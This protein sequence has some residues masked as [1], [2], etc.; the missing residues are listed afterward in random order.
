MSIF[1]HA[2]EFQ[3]SVE[4]RTFKRRRSP[5]MATPTQWPEGFSRPRASPESSGMP[6]WACVWFLVAAEKA[7]DEASLR[8]KVGRVSGEASKA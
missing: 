6:V 5:E 4:K 8:A 7:L 1:A 3:T 2:D